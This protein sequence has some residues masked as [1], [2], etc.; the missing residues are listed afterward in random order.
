[1]ANPFTLLIGSDEDWCAIDIGFNIIDHEIFFVTKSTDSMLRKI[2]AILIILGLIL[3]LESVPLIS[4][5]ISP[6]LISYI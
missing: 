3:A 6:N 4:S 1:M 2:E 5:L